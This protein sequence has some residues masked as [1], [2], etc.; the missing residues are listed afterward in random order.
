MDDRGVGARS[1]P[2]KSCGCLAAAAFLVVVGLPVLVVFSFGLAPCEHGPCDPDGGSRLAIVAAVLV[3]LSVLVG[4]ATWWA[5]GWWIRRQAARGRDG[6]RQL[7]LAA[8][9]LLALAAVALAALI[10][11]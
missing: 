3:G 8:V 2:G 1:A 7:Q 6:R 4:A 11:S 5:A 9:A 10:M